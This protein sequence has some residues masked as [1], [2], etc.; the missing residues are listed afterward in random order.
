MPQND[1]P[2]DWLGNL[3]WQGYPRLAPIRD[4]SS[5]ADEV[6]GAPRPPRKGPDVRVETLARE[7]EALRAKIENLAGLASEFE[8]SLSGAASSYEGAALESDSARRSTELENARLT[9]ELESAHSELARRE[10][11]ELARESELALERE[12]RA[13]C[14]KALLEA[15]RKLN[16]Q[17]ADLAATRSKG[18]ELSGSIG[19]L[20]RQAAASHERL[21]QAKVLTDQDVQILRAEMRE[22]LAKF[23]R[24]QET[25]A[26]TPPG[27]NR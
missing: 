7:N 24:I 11:R 15:R 14:E 2:R 23:H 9:G 25:F 19:E 18:A 21:L 8:R 4:V 10:A 1:D 27:E 20:R 17:E 5:A 22:F 13:D 6:P 3:N 26:D 12:R 16:D